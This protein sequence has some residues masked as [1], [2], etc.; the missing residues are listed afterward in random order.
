MGTKGRTD[1]LAPLIPWSTYGKGMLHM[2]AVFAELERDVI[3]ER[4]IAG[5]QRAKVRGTK[6]AERSGAPEL[7]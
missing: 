1:P 2:A 6:V 5:I 3:R 4:V 7:T